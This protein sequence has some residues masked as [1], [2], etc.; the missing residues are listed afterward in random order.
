MSGPWSKEEIVS[1]GH[2]VRREFDEELFR[3]IV[4]GL[5]RSD[6]ARVL[7]AGWEMPKNAGGRWD[8]K[9]EIYGTEYKIVKFEDQFA[10][11]VGLTPYHPRLND[12]S[13]VN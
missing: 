4:E 8:K 2:V 11:S 6:E 5:T 3:K 13:V 10:E 7:V 9:E 12:S 1:S